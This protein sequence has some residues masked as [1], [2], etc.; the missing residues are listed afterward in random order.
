[1]YPKNE[2]T[3]KELIIDGKCLFLQVEKSY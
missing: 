2:E 3:K 1:M